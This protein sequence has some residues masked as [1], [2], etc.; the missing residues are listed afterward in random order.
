LAKT[1]EPAAPTKSDKATPKPTLALRVWDTEA[2][3][4]AGVREESDRIMGSFCKPIFYHS[5]LPG[6]RS[7]VYTPKKM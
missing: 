6:N 7:A 1:G 2:A 4:Q 5:G 3:E